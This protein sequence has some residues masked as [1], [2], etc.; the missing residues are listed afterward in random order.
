MKNLIRAATIFVLAAFSASL[1][2]AEDPSDAWVKGLWLK[3]V[4]LPDGAGP[5]DMSQDDNEPYFIYS[6]GESG[7]GPAV[8]IAVGRYPQNELAEKILKLDKKALA[9]FD[10]AENFLETAKDLKFTE[11]P[12]KIS[13]KLTYPC[14]MAAYTNADMGLSHTVLFI[15]TDPYLFSVSVNRLTKDKKYGEADVEKWLMDLELVEQ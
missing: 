5:E 1:A 3:A 7:D 9:E 11:A 2:F 6:F 4:G 10:G 12:A 15:Q 8:T 13:D 14:Q